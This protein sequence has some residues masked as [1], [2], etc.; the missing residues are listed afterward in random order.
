MLGDVRDP[1]LVRRETVEFAMDE[2][3]AGG[4]AT[5]AFDL[6]RPGQAG[7]SGQAHQL[8]DQ[9]LADGDV[10]AAGQFGMDPAGSVGAPAG[11]VDLPDEP[12]QPL[13]AHPCR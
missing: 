7:D 12:G 9:M 1:E 11:G 13:P 8:R 5:E 10:H 2:V 6:R 4:D 3:I